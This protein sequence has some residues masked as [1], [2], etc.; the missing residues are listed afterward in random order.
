[1]RTALV[2]GSLIALGVAFGYMA[3]LLFAPRPDAAKTNKPEAP[4]TTPVAQTGAVGTRLS[5]VESQL[6]ALRARMESTGAAPAPAAAPEAHAAESIPVTP[7]EELAQQKAAWHEHMIEV[8]AGYASEA[9]DP[10]WARE[11]QSVITQ[12]LDGLPA[13]SKGLRSMDCRSETC[14]VEV[15]NDHQPEFD[16]QLPLLPLGLRGL[17][18]AQFDQ[19][20]EP[21]GKMRTVVYLTRQTD[22]PAAGG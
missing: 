7:A 11:A 5:F 2:R 21:D 13:L 6:A 16:K 14:R 8:E 10:R 20:A 4:I 9:R 22:A 19:V 1:M 15:V 3:T 17:P 18:S 12:A